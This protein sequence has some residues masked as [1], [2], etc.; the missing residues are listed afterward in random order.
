M[1]FIKYHADCIV[2][3]PFKRNIT[4]VKCYQKN[5]YKIIYEFNDFDTH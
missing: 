1:I 2:L 3:R 4:A 5:N